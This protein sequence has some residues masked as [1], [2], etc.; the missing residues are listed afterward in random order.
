MR[1]KT[2]LQNSTI[3]AEVWVKIITLYNS[4]YMM[5]MVLTEKWSNTFFVAKNFKGYDYSAFT[6]PIIRLLPVQHHV[7]VCV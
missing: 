3:E 5:K 1:A 4:K 6:G 2:R 7:N